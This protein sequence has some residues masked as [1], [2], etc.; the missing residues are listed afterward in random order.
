MKRPPW[1]R[2]PPIGV[3]INWAHPMAQGLALYWLFNEQGGAPRD[4]VRRQQGT[5]GTGHVWG[6]STQGGFLGG[7]GAAELTGTTPSAAILGVPFTVNV[8]YRSTSDIDSNWFMRM[9]SADAS[10]QNFHFGDGFAVYLKAFFFGAAMQLDFTQGK[11]FG[12]WTDAVFSFDG[13]TMRGFVNGIPCSST[14]TPGTPLTSDGEW[15]ILGAHYGSFAGDIARIALWHGRAF[16]QADVN[17]LRVRPYGL[18]TPRLARWVQSAGG[19]VEPPVPVDQW[20]PVGNVIA[21]RRGGGTASG[22][23]PH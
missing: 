5:L 19:D 14:G 4:L 15:T 12:E 6:T 17:E 3:G 11:I 21:R 18:L 22:M 9:G 7:T 2:K 1:A 10:F 16:T 8:L 20:A 13:T 23:T